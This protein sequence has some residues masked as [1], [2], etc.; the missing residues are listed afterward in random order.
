MFIVIIVIICVWVLIASNTPDKK[1]KEKV[2]EE[3]EKTSKNI[4]QK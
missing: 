4:T 2:K 1:D 3:I